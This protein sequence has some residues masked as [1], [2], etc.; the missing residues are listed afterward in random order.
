M[1][2]SGLYIAKNNGEEFMVVF[3]YG[4]LNSDWMEDD[5]FNNL[6]LLFFIDNLLL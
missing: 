3:G 5:S 6:D 1:E 2:D 4:L